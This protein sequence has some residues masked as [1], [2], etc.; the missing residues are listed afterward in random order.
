MAR[1]TAI[2]AQDT[3]ALGGGFTSPSGD[4]TGNT[5][6]QGQVSHHLALTPTLPGIPPLSQGHPVTLPHEGMTNWM[7]LVVDGLKTYPK[8]HLLQPRSLYYPKDLTI[9]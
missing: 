4:M 5:W 8:S 3:T 9:P 7:T 6:D 1:E 2:S